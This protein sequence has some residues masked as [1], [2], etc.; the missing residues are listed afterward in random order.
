MNSFIDISK[1]L[2]L[3]FNKYMQFIESDKVL[4]EIYD[5]HKKILLSSDVSND[6]KK[7]SLD[8][9]LK[10][11]DMLDK[12][13][14]EIE[15]D[16]RNVNYS[17][18]INNIMHLTEQIKKIAQD[19]I[20]L[21]KYKKDKDNNIKKIDPFKP[22][23]EHYEAFFE[24]PGI[25][26]LLDN[27][28]SDSEI[29]GK[30]IEVLKD[31]NKSDSER[32]SA[33]SKLDLLKS[34]YIEI[35]NSLKDLEKEDF[36]I[37]NK[38][39]IINL[40]INKDYAKYKVLILYPS[41]DEKGK[42]YFDEKNGIRKKM[43]VNRKQFES[44]LLQNMKGDIRILDSKVRYASLEKQSFWIAK[45][46][47]DN[48]WYKVLDIIDS[49]IPASQPNGGNYYYLEGLNKPVNQSNIIDLDEVDSEIEL[50]YLNKQ[51]SKKKFLKM[52][53]NKI[54]YQIL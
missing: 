16:F 40:P 52:R 5:Y 47:G 1:K 36:N 10:L 43:T 41:Y 22:Y 25:K 49:K 48:K 42:K 31:I 13:I 3:Y 11:R 24:Q 29:Y 32:R 46:K 37:N 30:A 34:K 19:V 54:Q 35:I 28:S 15:E 21:N 4:S 38:K 8:I 6:R 2:D 39:N 9:L 50:E 18:K 53:N 26:S 45:V 33:I 7:K 12:K 17:P 51:A 20:D 23:I 44:L 27:S 14:K